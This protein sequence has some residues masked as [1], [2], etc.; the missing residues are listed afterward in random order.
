MDPENGALIQAAAGNRNR[1]S[2]A[3]NNVGSN[4]NYWTFAPYSRAY[5]RYLSF[6]SGYVY[7]LYDNYRASGLAVR[8]ARELGRRGAMCFFIS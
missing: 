8:S 4:G 3:L 5:A 2:G 7:P 6:G 1:T